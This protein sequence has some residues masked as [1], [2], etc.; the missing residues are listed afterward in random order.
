MDNPCS[1]G[2]DHVGEICTNPVV[3][4]HNLCDFEWDGVHVSFKLCPIL[5]WAAEYNLFSNL[6]LILLIR[7]VLK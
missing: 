5:M 3:A 7:V 1:R 4:R 6:V 2:N